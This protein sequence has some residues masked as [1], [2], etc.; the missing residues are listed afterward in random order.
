MAIPVRG[1]LPKPAAP[2]PLPGLTKGLMRVALGSGDSPPAAVPS[3]QRY[4][5]AVG[6]L[7][8]ALGIA[9]APRAQGA[10]PGLADSRLRLVQFLK[11]GRGKRSPQVQQQLQALQGGGRQLGPLFQGWQPELVRQLLAGA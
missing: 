8:P 11:A 5:A 2:T 4:P 6:P 1:P 9:S 7:G 10:Q 3:V